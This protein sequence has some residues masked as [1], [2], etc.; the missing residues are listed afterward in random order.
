MG[1]GRIMGPG[2]LIHASVAFK[3]D[4]QPQAND[5]NG[6]IDWSK[7]VGQAVVADGKAAD[8]MSW[9]RQYDVELDLLDESLVKNKIDEFRT[10]REQALR[11]ETLSALKTLSF[12]AFSRESFVFILLIVPPQHDIRLIL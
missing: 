5:V 1:Q 11:A 9:A 8:D 10:A 4:Y 6:S 2:Q 12:M 7:I 3:E